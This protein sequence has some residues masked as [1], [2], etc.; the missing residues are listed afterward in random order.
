MSTKTTRLIMAARCR[1]KR[2]RTSWVWLRCRT[3]NSCSSRG[4]WVP[5]EPGA[6]MSVIA[7]P[8]VEHG[9]EE[10]GDEVEPDDDDGGQQQPRHGPVDVD[11]RGRLDEHLAHTVPLEDRLRDHGSTEDDRDVE[12]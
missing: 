10:V 8:R 9:V 2:R 11:G 4:S 1:R 7:D 6:S 3:V 12:G 5:A